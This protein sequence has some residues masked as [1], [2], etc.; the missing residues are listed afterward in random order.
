MNMKVKI[1]NIVGNKYNPRVIKDDKFNKLK[2]SISEFPE[3]IP[4]KLILCGEGIEVVSDEVLKK[5]GDG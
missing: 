4:R 2:K 3:M 5:C 1:N